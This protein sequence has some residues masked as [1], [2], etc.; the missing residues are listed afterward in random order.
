MERTDHVLLVGPGA[1]AFAAEQGVEV[2]PVDALVTP[3]ARPA[4]A[5]YLSVARPN[6]IKIG[7]IKPS[8]RTSWGKFVGN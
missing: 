7:R 5:T 6:L 2:L 3:E 1:T 8:L 4:K